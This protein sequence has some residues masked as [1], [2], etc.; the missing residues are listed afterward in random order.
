MSDTELRESSTVDVIQPG[1]KQLVLET[2]E[3]AARQALSWIYW[4]YGD[5]ADAAILPFVSFCIMEKP[6]E[7]S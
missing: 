4:S 2:Y 7:A 5:Q 6:R 1:R 3:L